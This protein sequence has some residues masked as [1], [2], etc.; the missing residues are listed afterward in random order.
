MGES[1]ASLNVSEV[2]RNIDL[3]EIE[4]KKRAEEKK[5]TFRQPM[6]HVMKPQEIDDAEF[7]ELGRYSFPIGYEREVQVEEEVVNKVKEKVGQKA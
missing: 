7:K 5:Q 4:E 3:K 6:F 1:N 2:M